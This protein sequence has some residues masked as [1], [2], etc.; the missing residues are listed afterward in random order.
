[1]T[2]LSLGERRRN[3]SPLP[4][5]EAKELRPSPLGRGEGTTALSLGERR[6][7]YGP[8]PWGEGVPRRRLHQPPRDG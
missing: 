4:W 1:M 7:N 6:R 5:G 3:Y 8:L 2:A